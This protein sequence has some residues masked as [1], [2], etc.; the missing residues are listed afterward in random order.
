MKMTFLMIK[1]IF[2]FLVCFLLCM[3]SVN[4]YA[5]NDIN[6][7]K[8]KNKII[9]SVQNLVQ[10][11]ATFIIGQYSTKDQRLIKATTFEIKA[12]NG[13]YESE[14]INLSADYKYKFFIWDNTENIMPLYN[15]LSITINT[16]DGAG[17]S[18]DGEY[19]KPY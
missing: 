6:Y 12:N 16:P 8:Y 17:S 14:I 19:T 11:K 3:T 5:L 18:G 13:M 15:A 7:Y 1:R 4:V 9:I 2:V 10:E